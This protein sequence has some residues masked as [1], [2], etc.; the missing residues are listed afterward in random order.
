MDVAAD[1][2]QVDPDRVSF[3]FLHGF[4]DSADCWQRVQRRLAEAGHGSLAVDQPSHGQAGALDVARYRAFF[5]RCHH[6]LDDGGSLSLQTIANE[7]AV[8]DATSRASAFITS[9]IFPESTLPRPSEVVVAAEPWFRLI[10]LRSDPDDYAATLRVWRN[11]L[12]AVRTEAVE[13]VGEDQ[14]QRYQ[15]YLK[16]SELAFRMRAC[17][18]LRLVFE[19]RPSPH[20]SA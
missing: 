18:L 11:N 14:Y 16:L 6:V 19:R 7:D 2:A 4:S 8:E 10:G 12:R 5:D 13:L 9:D 3:L 17:T 15:R 1:H 20:R